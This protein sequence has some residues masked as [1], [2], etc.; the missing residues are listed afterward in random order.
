MWLGLLAERRKQQ[1]FFDLAARFR[2]ETDPEAAKRLGDQL[3]TWFL[4]VDAKDR[5]MGECSIRKSRRTT[6]TGIS[7]RSNCADASV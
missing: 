5:T 3:G 7:D 6:G 4:V 1:E 2:E